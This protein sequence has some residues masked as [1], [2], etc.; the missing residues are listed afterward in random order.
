VLR[1]GLAVVDGGVGK[2]H[3]GGGSTESWHDI[4]SS[5]HCVSWLAF[6]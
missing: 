6:V 3:I 1:S 5:E 4:S 2:G